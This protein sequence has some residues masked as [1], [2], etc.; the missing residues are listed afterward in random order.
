M[1]EERKAREPYSGA[2]QERSGDMQEARVLSRAGRGTLDGD[3]SRRGG[4]VS[5]GAE[6]PAGAG[7][8]AV[9]LR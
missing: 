7:L 4:G 2:C 1:Q 9:S 8:A 5:G 6:P 3:E